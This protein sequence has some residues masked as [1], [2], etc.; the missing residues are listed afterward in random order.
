MVRCVMGR[1]RRKPIDSLIL[2]MC[3]AEF[4]RAFIHHA[5]GGLDGAADFFRD[6][7]G[8]IVSRFDQRGLDQLADG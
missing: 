1:A 6:G 8:R 7:N 3:H 2:G 4:L 5:N